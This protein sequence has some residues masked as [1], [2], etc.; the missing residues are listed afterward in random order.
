MH[1]AEYFSQHE[2]SRKILLPASG[3]ISGECE[4][5]KFAIIISPPYNPFLGGNCVCVRKKRAAAHFHTLGVHRCFQI[6][7]R[8]AS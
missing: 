3:A 4:E 6:Y 2:I 7:Y 5:R 8:G 1:T